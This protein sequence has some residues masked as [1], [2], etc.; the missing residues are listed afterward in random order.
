MPDSS[1]TARAWGRQSFL[2]LLA[3]LG[4][5]LSCGC[6]AERPARV[7]DDLSVALPETLDEAAL[8]RRPPPRGSTA[9]RVALLLHGSGSSPRMFLDVADEISRQGFVALVVRGPRVLGPD[10]YS[11]SS[12]E[13]THALLG[14]IV[15][16][17]GRELPIS[18]KRPILVGYSL[19]ATLAVHL[20]A[21]HPDVYASAFAISPGPLAST[22][23]PPTSLSRP[24]VILVGSEDG[25]SE[26]AVAGIAQA[27][28]AAKEPLWVV[29]HPG[30]HRPPD[31]WR[32]RFDDAMTWV[33]VKADS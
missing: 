11:W 19:G 12:D 32:D 6:Q 26:Q 24:L 15:E 28:A 22:H 2:V 21:Q 8:V 3:L 10:R 31:D 27:W 25:P 23:L 4:V 29:H 14:R 30:D 20:L 1:G 9:P 33:T 7:G 13:E 17:A 18:R 16:L 5:S